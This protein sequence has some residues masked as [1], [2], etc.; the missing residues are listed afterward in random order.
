MAYTVVEAVQI[1]RNVQAFLSRTDGRDK[2][3]KFFQN[4]FRYLKHFSTVDESKIWKALQNSLSEFRSV[5]KFGKPLKNIIELNDMLV[6][7]GGKGSLRIV[8]YI[9][10]FS[11]L[12][13]VGYKLG[14]NFEYLS[15]YKLLPCNE[16]RCEAWSKTFQWYT[17]A[18]DVLVGLINMR[19]VYCIKFCQDKSDDN[20]R[21][22]DLRCVVGFIG[23]FADFLRV[24]P[25]FFSMYGVMKKH[26]GFSGAM[27]IV[28]GL[29]GCWRVWD[30]IAT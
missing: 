24:T 27:G 10:C 6:D 15:H 18:A 9:K 29:C 13:D 17:Y 3:A 2:L 28:V 23:D 5:I 7:S 8:L 25:G 19:E 11:L 30:E 14:D 21:R 16:F 4:Y 20:E 26:D 22:I 12:S 1:I